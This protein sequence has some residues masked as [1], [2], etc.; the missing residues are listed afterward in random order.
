MK[1]KK[2]QWILLYSVLFVIAVLTVFDALGVTIVI[3]P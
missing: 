1:S 2:A 3:H